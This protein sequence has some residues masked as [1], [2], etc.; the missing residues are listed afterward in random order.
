MF[1]WQCSARVPDEA[2]F[3]TS[4]GAALLKSPGDMTIDEEDEAKVHA[5]LAQA[6]LFRLR[7]DFEGATSR[8][9]EALKIHPSNASAHSLL[10][11]ICRDEDRPRDA[12][13][14]YK[15]ALTLD[16]T[17]KQDREKLDQLIDKIYGTSQ[18]SPQP[19]L[20]EA[21]PIA[22]S[23]PSNRLRFSAILLAGIALI[24]VI[25]AIAV[26]Y[27]LPESNRDNSL[28]AVVFH[29]PAESA[30]N[31]AQAPAASS[32]GEVSPA[33]S[34]SVANASAPPVAGEA[35]PA[36]FVG[37]EKREQKL[38]SDLSETAA[39]LPSGAELFSAQI[40]PRKRSAEIS[41]AFRSG[42]GREADKRQALNFA[43]Q[44]G[45]QAAQL[46]TG[47]ELVTTKIYLQKE[48][49]AGPEFE[50]FFVG[51]LS[52]AKLRALNLETLAPQQAETNFTNAWWNP[53]PTVSP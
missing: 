52:A 4:C 38:F 8:C 17:R 47:L 33:P 20:V 46:E 28:P 13:E 36:F 40:E 30:A 3:C 6:N 14:W 27:I 42:E 50:V 32:A 37:L 44:L 35:D 19:G 21:K 53:A 24:S 43:L 15:L 9:T 45:K 10:G 23:A 22:K 16:P 41:F 12:M 25:F 51:D 29:T 39:K 1:C 48:T 34:S 49:S 11:D 7:R 2:A 31:S 18:G 5:L 26:V